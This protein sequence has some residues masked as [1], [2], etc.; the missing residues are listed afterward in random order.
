[1]TNRYAVIENGLVANVVV[2][3]AEFAAQNGWIACPDAGPGWKYDGVAFTEPD[4]IPEP[5]P[6]P[7]PTKEQLMAELAALTAKIQALE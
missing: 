5:T 4:P 6:A 2:A 1:M 3:D 7:A